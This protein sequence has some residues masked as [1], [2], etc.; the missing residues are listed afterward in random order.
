MTSPKI[1][2]KQLLKKYSISEAVAQATQCLWL[3]PIYKK[4]YWNKVLENINDNE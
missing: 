1:K 4:E 3:A 2:A